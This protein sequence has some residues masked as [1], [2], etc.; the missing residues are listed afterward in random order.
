MK[1]DKNER[2]YIGVCGNHKAGE[3]APKGLPYC[4]TADYSARVRYP[5]DFYVVLGEY[6]SLKA[7][8]AALPKVKR[9]FRK[10]E[11]A[12]AKLIIRERTSK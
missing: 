7:A 2:P 12:A 6:P 8:M 5:N 10:L 9:D 3:K 11:D 1:R 4:I